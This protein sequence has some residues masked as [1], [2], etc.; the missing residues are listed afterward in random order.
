MRRTALPSTLALLA[1]L[2]GC[3]DPAKRPA[4]E[5]IKAAEATLAAARPDAA[6]YAATQLQAADEAIAK[7]KA[8]FAREDFK[9]ALADGQAAKAKASEAVAFATGRRDDY[10]RNFSMAVAQLPQLHDLIEGKLA[11]LS[12]AKQ[13]PKG[14]TKATLASAAEQLAA[15]RKLL[16]EATAKASSGDIEGAAAAARPLRDTSL[17]IAWSLGIDLGWRPP[18]A[19]R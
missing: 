16:G 15:A 8:S 1:L 10:G 3:A 4:E 12:A 17:A 19:A 14:V 6:R 2:A 5:A 18:K 11:E 7:A 9:G 13:L